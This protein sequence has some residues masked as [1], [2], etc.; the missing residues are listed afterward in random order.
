[1]DYK[2]D[3]KPFSIRRTREFH[4]NVALKSDFPCVAHI[5]SVYL[6]LIF[7]SILMFLW[8]IVEIRM[9]KSLT[10]SFMTAKSIAN[11]RDAKANLRTS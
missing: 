2:C 8:F 5:K 1:M 7:K 11:M 9:T 4:G 3:W 6:S 10:Y